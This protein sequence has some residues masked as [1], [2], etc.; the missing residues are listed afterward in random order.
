MSKNKYFQ[1]MRIETIKHEIEVLEHFVRQAREQNRLELIQHFEPVLL[2]ARA[3]LAY[4]KSNPAAQ[5]Y[6]DTTTENEGEN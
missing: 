4:F 5:F 6:P 2:R 3:R 1:H